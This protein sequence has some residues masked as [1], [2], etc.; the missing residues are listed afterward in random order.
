M[1]AMSHTPTMPDNLDRQQTT[2]EE[3]NMET[4]TN[5][6]QDY[7]QSIREELVNLDMVLELSHVSLPEDSEE[8]TAQQQDLRA[9]ITALEMD[10]VSDGDYFAN[11]LNETILETVVLRAENGSRSRVEMLRT[12]GGPRCDIFFESNDGSN[13][14]IE[15]YS[16]SE[17]GRCRVSLPDLAAA[18][19]AAFEVE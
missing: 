13:L 14:T 8:D 19:S 4:I 16:G 10:H 11:Y 2:T 12:C 6:A 3:E 7:A 15:V 17:Y 1:G 9:A 5:T 18:L